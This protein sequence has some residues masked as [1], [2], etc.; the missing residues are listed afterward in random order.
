MRLALESGGVSPAQVD[1][2][3]AHGSSTPLNDS[4]E[5]RVL[6]AVLGDHAHRAA[7][8]GTKAYTGHALGATGAMEAAICAL[9]V[10][11]GWAPPT[12][13]LEDPDPEC[14]LPYVTGEGVH[15]EI[16]HAVSNSFGFGG[17]NASL[18]FS[19]GA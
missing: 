19:R 10:Q 4:T 7:V 14:D 9:A 5:T 8:S 17:I 13:N 11:R 2:V 12:L 16:R 6:H 3:N 18:L 1:Y 15:R